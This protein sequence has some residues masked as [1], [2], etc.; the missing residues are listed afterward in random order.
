MDEEE[1]IIEAVADTLIKEVCIE[2]NILYKQNIADFNTN[3]DGED[4]SDD[5]VPRNT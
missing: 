1:T 4:S 5:R 2:N 3:S